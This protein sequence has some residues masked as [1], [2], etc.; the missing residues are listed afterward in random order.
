MSPPYL[1]TDIQLVIARNMRNSDGSHRFRNLNSFLQCNRTLYGLLN[2]RLWRE[3]AEDVA[4]THRVLTHVIMNNDI[5]GLERLL[6]Y[7]ADPET[8]LPSF[9]LPELANDEYDYRRFHPTPLV[10]AASFDNVPMA[11]MLLA[12]GA[13]VQS[14]IDS[15]S[16]YSALHAA[17]S[18]AMVQLLMDQHADPDWLDEEDFPPIIWH[19]RRQDRA[20]IRELLQRRAD[21]NLG[22]MKPLCTAAELNLDLVQLLLSHGAQLDARCVSGETAIHCA[23][24]AGKLDIIRFLVG[25]W[26]EGLRTSDNNLFTPLHSAACSGQLAVLKFLVEQWPQGMMQGDGGSETP[27]HIAAIYGHTEVVL[28]LL[29][30]W[31]QGRMA[32]NIHLQTPLSILSEH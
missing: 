4:T 30:Q 32:L 27:F 17:R 14:T 26:P 2:H 19:I 8:R 28:F 1:F 16:S 21:V 18:P 13:K 7:G 6:Q 3:A 12:K 9:E 23:A 22:W 24:M 10:I 5:V 11:T 20:S 29:G 25:A 31:P 15:T